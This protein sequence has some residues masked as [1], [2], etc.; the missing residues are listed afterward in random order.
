MLFADLV[1]MV[2]ER[3][4]GRDRAS[5]ID[6]VIVTASIGLVAWVFLIVPYV[7]ETDLGLVERFVSIGQLPSS[8]IDSTRN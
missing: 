2:R 4:A 6:A 1:L 7:R 8:R 3:S 5:M